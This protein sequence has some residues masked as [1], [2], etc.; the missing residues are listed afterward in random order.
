MDAGHTTLI[1]SSFGF[2]LVDRSMKLTTRP[3]H[4]DPID[5][6]KIVSERLRARRLLL[7][8]SQ[9]D[10]GSSTG[11]S[12]QQV[13]KYETAVSRLTAGRLVQFASVLKV[14]I[15]YF[16]DGVETEQETPRRIISLLADPTTIELLQHF[17]RL[18][19]PLRLATSTYVRALS[20]ETATV[21]EADTEPYAHL[22]ASPEQPAEADLAGQ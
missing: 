22:S 17:W 18:P 19:K 20:A 10:L 11:I 16:Y 5:V 12:P 1:E 6:D 21:S 7:G 13:H 2:A 3:D 14:P 4:P 8:I 15:A 9:A